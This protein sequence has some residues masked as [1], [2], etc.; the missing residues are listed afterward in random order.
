MLVAIITYAIVFNAEIN[1]YGVWVTAKIKNSEEVENGY[2]FNYE[3]FYQG[4]KFGAH[5]KD[6]FYVKDTFI[7]IKVS[8]KD[9]ATS[10]YFA[11]PVPYC[12]KNNDSMNKYWVEFPICR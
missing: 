8:K 9:P 12:L 6:I 1:K 10:K 3:Y 11:G 7:M 4:K 5:F 2:I